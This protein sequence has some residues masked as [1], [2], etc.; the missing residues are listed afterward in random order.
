MGVRVVLPNRFREICRTVVDPTT[1]ARIRVPTDWTDTMRH[2][3][4]AAAGATLKRLGYDDPSLPR[5]LPAKRLRWREPASVVGQTGQSEFDIE[6]VLNIGGLSSYAP[7]LRMGQRIRRGVSQAI[8]RLLFRPSASMALD[9]NDQLLPISATPGT[10]V[11]LAQGLILRPGKRRRHWVV[12]AEGNWHKANPETLSRLVGV[13]YVTT[14]FSV[15]RMERVALLTLRHLYYDRR[16]QLITPYT[17]CFN[18][19]PSFLQFGPACRFSTCPPQGAV[20][21]ALGINFDSDE[22]SEAFVEI[23]ELSLDLARCRRAA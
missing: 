4:A 14:S 18:F 10:L 15:A 7:L 20:Y 23:S 17:R 13:N 11:E 5:V 1:S 6:R 3:F 22:T 19:T 2:E 12:L 16:G 8:G 21:V 9:E